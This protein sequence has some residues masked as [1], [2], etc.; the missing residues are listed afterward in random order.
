MIISMYLS[1][2]RI[3]IIICYPRIDIF[4]LLRYSNSFENTS[5]AFIQIVNLEIVEELKDE[6]YL[7]Y[8]HNFQL[9]S[10]HL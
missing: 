5:F 8:K 3:Q 10:F 7:L 6:I 1:L 4:L 2:N 9:E